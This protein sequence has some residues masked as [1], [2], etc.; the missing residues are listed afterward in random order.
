MQNYLHKSIQFT[1]LN[2]SRAQNIL[3][4]HEYMNHR[5]TLGDLPKST[6]GSKYLILTDMNQREP[7]GDPLLE[8]GVNFNIGL[9]ACQP[10][11]R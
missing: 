2:A 5:E 9:G 10:E 11:L 4:L 6:Q 8:T 7:L 3:H 1:Q